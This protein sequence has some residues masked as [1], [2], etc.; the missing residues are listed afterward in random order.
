MYHC[1]LY[2]LPLL[3][4]SKWN[5]FT[6]ILIDFFSSFSWNILISFWNIFLVWL[7]YFSC[8]FLG[9]TKTK[10]SNLYSGQRVESRQQSHFCQSFCQSGFHTL[11]G[12]KK[13]CLRMCSKQELYARKSNKGNSVPQKGRPL[14]NYEVENVQYFFVRVGNETTH[15]NSVSGLSMSF[16]LLLCYAFHQILILDKKAGKSY[17]G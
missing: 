9:C 8:F 14:T 3:N 17:L 6:F 2:I 10:K 5:I 11:R 13:R 4:F 16:I 7:E 1:D 12:N 15:L